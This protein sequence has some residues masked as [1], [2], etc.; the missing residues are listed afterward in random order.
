MHQAKSRSA[1]VKVSWKDNTCTDFEEKKIEEDNWCEITIA[2]SGA[3]AH[4]IKE[5]KKEVAR[6]TPLPK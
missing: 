1:S 6:P 2:I 5:A 3:Q 4:I